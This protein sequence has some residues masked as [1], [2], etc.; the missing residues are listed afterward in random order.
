MDRS[1]RFA[2]SIQKQAGG[3]VSRSAGD[4]FP[5]ENGAQA[6]AVITY[7]DEQAVCSASHVA[8]LSRAACP[9]D[10]V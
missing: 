9:P 10:R 7:V 2:G 4:T 8:S 3:T 5:M 1:F 6:S